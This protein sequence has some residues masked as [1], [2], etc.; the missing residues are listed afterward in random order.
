MIL[1][2]IGVSVSGDRLKA[3]L[4]VPYQE[5][6][7]YPTVEE[8]V[9]C[10]H[11]HGIAFG[12]N[13]T[14]LEDMRQKKI[15]NRRILVCEGVDPVAGENA[16][17]EILVDTASRGKP[18]IDEDGRVDLRNIQLVINV[19]VGHPLLRKIPAG[20][21]VDGKSVF[22][23]TVPARPGE[24][25]LF[26]AGTGTKT[27]EDNPLILV[28]AN[29]GAVIIAGDGRV[30]VIKSEVISG[31][32]D[33]NTG[34]VSFTGDLSVRGAVRSGFS[35]DV[36]GNLH[37]GGNI[38]E[39]NVHCTGN[40][41][42]RGGATGSGEGTITCGGSCRIR[43]VERVTLKS[44]SDITIQDSAIHSTIMAQ[45]AITAKIII[46]GSVYAGESIEA[47]IIG[48]AAGTRTTLDVGGT[49][50]VLD[51]KQVLLKEKEA[52][53]TELA[54]IRHSQ[55]EIVN[56]SMDINGA[57]GALEEQTLGHL[58]QQRTDL[59]ERA[60]KLKREIHDIEEKMLKRPDPFVKAGKILPNT[61]IRF[62]PRTK[63]IKSVLM[64]VVLR[65]DEDRIKLLK[66]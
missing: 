60:D 34:N 23:E 30:E 22:G 64:N 62:G 63:L 58:W 36:K 6:M 25:R 41:D 45:G 40:L 37:I 38:E 48:A 52:Y 53:D 44:G 24:D 29:D 46:G 59:E 4:M 39:C 10:L 7:V 19:D 11:E 17:F 2:H 66:Y 43:M 5:G 57:I 15:C 14:V 13:I 8:M 32:V 12:I 42:V 1:Q 35:V 9:D 65:V 3:Y 31:D 20:K 47:G 27:A 54:I 51:R 50:D 26:P 16:G 28:A 49:V 55:F 33:Y 56:T 18:Q 61:I 21:G